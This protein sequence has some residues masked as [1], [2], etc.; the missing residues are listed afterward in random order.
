MPNRARSAIAPEI[1][2]TVMIANVAWKPANASV[3][4]LFAA[5]A[6]PF[7]SSGISPA[8]G[9]GFPSTPWISQA[10]DWSGVELGKAMENP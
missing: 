8:S 6:P 3:F 4:R 1:S 5:P 9:M 7:V 2:A 10:C